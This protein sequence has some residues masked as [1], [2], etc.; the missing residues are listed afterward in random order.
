MSLIRAVA[1]VSDPQD[2]EIEVAVTMTLASWRSLLADLRC[3][4]MAGSDFARKIREVV[5]KVESNAV[6]LDSEQSGVGGGR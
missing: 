2:V 6:A 4:T 3:N 1:R 5:S